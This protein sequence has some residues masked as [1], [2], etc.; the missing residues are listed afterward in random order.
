MTEQ[1]PDLCQPQDTLT[2]V[3][4]ASL[5]L[6]AGSVSKKTMETL[7]RTVVES[8]AEFPWQVVTQAI[9]AEPIDEQKLVQQ[10]L[11]AQ[12]DW[13]LRGGREMPGKPVSVRAKTLLAKLL[14]QMIFLLVLSV[15]L[16]VA[17]LA[18]KYRWPDVD[19]YRALAWLQEVWPAL[20]RD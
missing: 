3:G 19:I 16:V 14:S 15:I 2:A 10:G 7:K 20:R 13:I 12:R 1:V 5:R 18:V 11:R 8:P 9:L 4:A 17:L 6:L